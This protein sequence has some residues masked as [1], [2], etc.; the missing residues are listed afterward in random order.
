MSAAAFGL[1]LLAMGKREEQPVSNGA[2][3]PR[4]V[5]IGWR[6]TIG[7]TPEEAWFLWSRLEH[8]PMFVPGLKSVTA[9]DEVHHQWVAADSNL[10]WRTVIVDDQP[11]RRI[12]WRAVPGSPVLGAGQL[13]F[14]S[15]RRGR[16][17]SVRFDL[18]YLAQGV[19]PSVAP[20]V[21]EVPLQEEHATTQQG[22]LPHH[23]IP[24]SAIPAA[25]RLSRPFI[26]DLEAVKAAAAE[27]LVA[28]A[29]RRFDPVS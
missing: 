19:A 23:D 13:E 16:A 22:D 26:P 2:T 3:P 12:E 18:W 4:P 25:P 8:L 28:A 7:K 9:E 5:K 1:A 29:N 15:R 10:S 27:D 21:A 20:P 14:H 17:T 11:G 24:Q 6:A